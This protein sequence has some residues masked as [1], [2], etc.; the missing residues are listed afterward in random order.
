MFPTCA[1]IDMLRFACKT[2]ASRTQTFTST[3]HFFSLTN[4]KQTELTWIVHVTHDP[5]HRSLDPGVVR[6]EHSLLTRLEREAHL[7]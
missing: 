4:P 1:N 7:H 6:V 3:T 5:V 2:F